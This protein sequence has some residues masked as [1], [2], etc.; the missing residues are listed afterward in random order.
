MKHILAGLIGLAM[1]IAAASAEAVITGP[2]G[3][4]PEAAY[5]IA[6]S[7]NQS[8]GVALA[9]AALASPAVASAAGTASASVN[10]G[11]PVIGIAWT[12]TSSALAAKMINRKSILA[13]ADDKLPPPPWAIPD[14]EG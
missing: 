1:C 14:R 8:N 5:L 4:G 11:N 2:P 3:S 13:V 6:V 9:S 12:D 7:V 10:L